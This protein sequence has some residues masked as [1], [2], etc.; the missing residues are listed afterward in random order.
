MKDGGFVLAID[1]PTNT[2]ARV[3]LPHMQGSALESGR[4][5]GEQKDVRYVG[6]SERGKETFEV[7]SGHYQF[8]YRYK[9]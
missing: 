4:P 5:A 7:G 8:S 6:T 3:L 9:N 1:I 2:T